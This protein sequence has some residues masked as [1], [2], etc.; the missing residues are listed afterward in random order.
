MARRRYQRRSHLAEAINRSS[1][2]MQKVWA[3]VIAIAFVFAM[4]MMVSH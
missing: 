4:V 3:A 1:P 2:G